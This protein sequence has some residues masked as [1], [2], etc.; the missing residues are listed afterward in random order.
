MF[1]FS[2]ISH[3]HAHMRTSLLLKDIFLKK[4][5]YDVIDI[6]FFPVCILT[7]IKMKRKEKKTSEIDENFV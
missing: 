7:S 5:S 4:E 6:S 3:T 1:F 2:L